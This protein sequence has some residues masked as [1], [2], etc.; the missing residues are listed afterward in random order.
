MQVFRHHENLPSTAR[1]AT[2]AIGNFDGVHRGHQALIRQAKALGGP[3]GVMVFEPHPQEYFRPDT[4]RFRLT[5][6]R[7]KARLLEKYGVDILYA[8]HFDAAFASLSADAFIE[9]VLV[10]GMGVSRVIV[11]ADFQFGKGRAGNRDLLMAR[12]AALGFGVTT[13]DLVGEGGDAKISS[14]RI[15]EALRDGKP[16][17]AA[18][19]L[20]H[21]WTVE[22]RVERGDQRG[23]T[24]GFP[25]A[26]VSLEGYL[27]PALGVY[28]VRVE[29]GG[30][31][32]D[33]VANFGRR[34]TFDKKDV[35]LEVH[36]FGFEGDIYGQPIVVSFIE[37]L[38]PEMKF[39]G[40]DALKAQITRDCE[41]ARNALSAL[42]P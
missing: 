17:V 22:G 31:L 27:E 4:P 33:G 36:V 18:R 23:R 10:E 28:A 12:G 42:S 3:L 8:L 9:R 39:A 38:R 37:F 24:I 5:P 20:G 19:M 34:P 7:A 15:R 29:L 25:T 21:P 35:L 11:G 16:D 26:N 40:L 30:R 6:F 32:H 1:G 2:V 41:T 14:T 13:I